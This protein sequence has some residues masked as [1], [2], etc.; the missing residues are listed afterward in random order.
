MRTDT[1]TSSERS[2]FDQAQRAVL[3]AGG[4]ALIPKEAF[5]GGPSLRG[6][7]LRPIPLLLRDERWGLSLAVFQFSISI[8]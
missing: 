2:R 3:W 4:R 6:L 7:H 5:G 8:F 1:N